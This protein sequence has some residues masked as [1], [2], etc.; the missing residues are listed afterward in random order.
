MGTPELPLFNNF[1][2]FFKGISNQKFA[3]ILITNGWNGQRSAWLEWELRNDWSDLTLQGDE[4][5][6]LLNGSV[7]NEPC[8]IDTLNSIFESLNCE[9]GYEFYDEMKNLLLEKRQLT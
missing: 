1:Y 9:Y 5:E 6:I 8:Y 4:N 7:I 2:S 3:E